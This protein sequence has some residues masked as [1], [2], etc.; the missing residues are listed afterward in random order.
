[1]ESEASILFTKN[2][3][4]GIVGISVFL[5]AFKYA[6]NIF[7]WI[8]KQT[9][10]TRTYIMEKL[11]LLFIEVAP[12]RVTYVLLF[13]SVGLGSLTLLIFGLLGHW[14]LGVILAI[15]LSFIGFKIP[16]PIVNFMIEKRIAQYEDQMVDGLTLLANGIRAG[17]SVPQALGMVVVELNPPISQEFNYIPVSYTHLTLPTTPYV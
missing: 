8:E 7:D 4:M 17:L 1:M 10:G 2:T 12:E 13:L 6:H 5:F 16:K 11:D 14:T 9:L 3:I 15:V